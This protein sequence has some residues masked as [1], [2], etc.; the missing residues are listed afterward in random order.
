MVQSGIGSKQV[1]D[2]RTPTDLYE[3]LNKEFGPF[4]RDPCPLG[5]LENPNVPDGLEISWDSKTFCNPPY[6]NVQKW[7]E[8]ALLEA[9]KGKLVVM[10]I[11]ARIQCKYWWEKIFP[12]AAEIRLCSKITFPGYNLPAPMPVSVVIF[13]GGKPTQNLVNERGVYSFVNLKA[14]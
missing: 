10:L 9:N 11:P 4:G 12:N 7:V 2:V 6:N 5:G 14:F 3:S 8:K 1:N 13:A